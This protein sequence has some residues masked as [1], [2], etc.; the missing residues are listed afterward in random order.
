MTLV[1][2]FK[3]RSKTIIAVD[4]QTSDPDG[5]PYYDS[6]GFIQIQKLIHLP[7]IKGALGI[8]GFLSCNKFNL[9][10]KLKEIR[11][12]TVYT[13]L[14]E[15]LGN[16]K[17]EVDLINQKEFKKDIS[18][19]IA[20]QYEGMNFVHRCYYKDTAK[21]EIYKDIQISAG[22]FNTMYAHILCKELRLDYREIKSS[23]KSSV[24]M[25]ILDFNFNYSMSSRDHISK[26]YTYFHIFFKLEYPESE[27]DVL[28]FLTNHQLC[29]FIT[30]FYSF[31]Q[32]LKTHKKIGDFKNRRLNSIGN[33]THLVKITKEKS[34]WILNV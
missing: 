34:D 28:E 20:S 2:R 18:I 31:I 33:C 15:F 9:I 25:E 11:D 19:L 17:K 16:V 1:S 6:T 8:S 29:A 3:F 32:S 12:N 5:K 24:Y 7:K 22:L 13:D 21:F 14:D 4:N 27:L 30:S 23:F 26:I 10:K